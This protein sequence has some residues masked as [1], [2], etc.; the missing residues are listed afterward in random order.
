MT[1]EESIQ[2][3]V[4]A[5]I[6]GAGG[7]TDIGDAGGSEGG[8]GGDTDIS[9]AGGNEGIELE[10]EVKAFSLKMLVVLV[11]RG[12]GEGAV[13]NTDAGRSSSR[14]S[15]RSA[16]LTTGH[17]VFDMTREESIQGIVDAD[18]GGAGGDTDIGD[19]GGSEGG[20]GGDTDIGCTGGSEGVELEDVGGSEGIELEDI[21]SFG[22]PRGS[23]EGAV[24]N[25][26][27]GGSSSRSSSRSA[28]LTTGHGGGDTNIGDAGMKV[29]QEG[30]L[31]LWYRRSEGIEL[32]DVGSFSVP[33]GSGG[34]AVG[35]IDA[36]I[37][38]TGGNEG[39]ELEDIS[40]F[41]VPRGS[42]EAAVGNTDAGGSSSRSSSRSAKLTTGHGG[43]GVKKEYPFI[44]TVSKEICPSL[45]QVAKV[46]HFDFVFSLSSFYL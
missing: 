32:E 7:D 19:A 37:G 43:S 13:G 41:G 34:D 44:F 6:G 46:I 12:S 25:T 21:S 11:P 38:G 15:S 35:N 39:I 17:G 26:D 4:D 42:G 27:A 16:R 23:G 40:C 2:G 10:D 14:S 1:R 8:A 29:V 9:G 36:D 31:I 30:I 20:A 5:D 33:R 3:T 24:G 45:I 18:I 22:V 28:R